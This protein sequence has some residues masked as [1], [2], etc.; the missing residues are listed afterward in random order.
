MYE[1]K[2]EA[3]KTV[4]EFLDSL[5]ESGIINMF[6]AGPVLQ[7]RFEMTKYDS[8]RHLAKWMETFSERH[9]QQKD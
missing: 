5:R 9:P 4:F 6:E 2:T 7:K 1:M 3:E 8:H